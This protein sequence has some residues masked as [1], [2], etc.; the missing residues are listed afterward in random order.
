MV[1]FWK[2]LFIFVSF[3]KAIYIY[4]LTIY[5]LRFRLVH[6]DAETKTLQLM[7]QHVE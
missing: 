6:L 1:I 5:N 2:L 7:Q 4:Y 3:L